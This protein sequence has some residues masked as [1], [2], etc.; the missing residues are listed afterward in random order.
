MSGKSAL[1][2]LIT[3]SLFF[4]GCAASNTAGKPEAENVDKDKAQTAIEAKDSKVEA[5][6]KYTKGLM[7]MSHG[8]MVDAEK[9]F[10]ESI[11]LDPDHV[12]THMFLARAYEKQKK[13]E[14]SADQYEAAMK[15]KP[16]DPNPYAGLIGIYLE[17]GLSDNAIATA[18]K[19]AKKGI[20]MS[21]YAGN[22][23]WAYYMKGDLVN[24][25]KYLKEAKEQSKDESVPRNN[26]GL[27][28]FRQGRY[29]DALANFKEA[30]ELNKQSVVLPYFLAL[31]YNKLGKDDEVANALREGLKRDPD[32]ESKVKSYKRRFFADDPGDLSAVFKKLK[33]EKN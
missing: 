14:E 11:K 6:D 12:S 28:Y 4:A 25:E 33:E 5:K 9:Y 24:A 1:S 29:E 16:E 2:L 26:L 10:L 19:A 17:K 30:S 3:L 18:E 21:T 31:T 7:A 22:L 15:L 20:P 32:I 8:N 13:Y 23:G 27:L